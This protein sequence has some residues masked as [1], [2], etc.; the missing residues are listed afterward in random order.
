MT[1]P[2]RDTSEVDA[3]R[4]TFAVPELCACVIWDSLMSGPL[5]DK[6]EVDAVRYTFVAPELYVSL[7]T[8]ACLNQFVTRRKLKRFVTPSPRPNCVCV[9]VSYVTPS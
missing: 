8:Y 7:W 6:S 1:E 4:D 3:V 5:R 9:C 2:V